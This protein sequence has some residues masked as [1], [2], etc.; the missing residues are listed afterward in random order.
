M[1]QEQKKAARTPG[2]GFWSAVSFRWKPH[3]SRR[4]RTINLE[5]LSLK[6]LQTSTADYAC[7][8]AIYEDR[9]DEKLRVDT[10]IITRLVLDK[11]DDR[12]VLPYG[13]YD[14]NQVVG[15][16][17]LTRYNKER[18]IYADYISIAKEV[19]SYGV[20]KTF[21]RRMEEEVQRLTN[22]FVLFEAEAGALVR[23]Y[24]ALGAGTV[25]YMHIM[26]VMDMTLERVPGKVM[27]FPKPESIDRDR[28]LECLSA[29]LFKGYTDWVT[30]SLSPEDAVRYQQYIA[31]LYDELKDLIP[32]AVRVL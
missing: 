19:G 14:G 7:A 11:Q 16:C 27:I 23:F 1:P 17:L 32:E 2:S 13:L 12:E 5:D 24:R 6:L 22:T 4:K 3:K 20:G 28:Y 21:L 15:F 18:F 10:D 9:F 26:P 30:L 29:M 8:L 25:D 31:D